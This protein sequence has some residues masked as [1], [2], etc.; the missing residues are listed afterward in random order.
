M[1]T[2]NDYLSNLIQLILPGNIVTLLLHKLMNFI[3]LD[4]SRKLALCQILSSSALVVSLKA[5]QYII[6]NLLPGSGMLA[7]FNFSNYID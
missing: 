2:L 5:F 3:V 6:N 1:D 7:L 4:A